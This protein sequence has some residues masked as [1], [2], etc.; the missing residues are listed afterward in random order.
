MTIIP[1]QRPVLDIDASLALAAI[2]ADLI[3]IRAAAPFA[4]GACR[5]AQSAF[6]SAFTDPS[7]G[8]WAHAADAAA[9]ALR[10]SAG[11]TGMRAVAARNRLAE[12]VAENADLI[13][14]TA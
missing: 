4:E 8:R 14:R 10:R 2:D 11:V 13:E 5:H 3:A 7:E 6:A 1:A 12:F 9:T